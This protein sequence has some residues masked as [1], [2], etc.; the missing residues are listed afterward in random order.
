[1]AANS[2]IEPVTVGKQAPVVTVLRCALTGAVL[3]VYVSPADGSVECLTS[4]LSELP[5]LAGPIAADVIGS[6]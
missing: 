5:G 2:K 4:L 3:G 1:M 6:P